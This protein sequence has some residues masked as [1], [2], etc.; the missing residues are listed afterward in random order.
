MAS[1]S[2]KILLQFCEWQ[3]THGTHIENAKAYL[4]GVI[5]FLN[6]H[7]FQI[8]RSNLASRLLHPQVGQTAY[9]WTTESTLP[10]TPAG[11]QVVE[12]SE[13]KFDAARVIEL[14]F[15]QGTINAAPIKNSPIHRVL[16]DDQSVYEKIEKNQ[17]TFHYPVLVD[18]HAMGAT[19]YIALP[20]RFSRE[21]RAFLSFASRK[22]GGL[23]RV[24][25]AALEKIAP[26]FAL[27]WEKFSKEILMESLLRLYLGEITGPQVLGGKI[28]RGEMDTIESVVWFSDIR[29]FTVMSTIMQPQELVDLLNTY[30]AVII[31]VIRSYGGEV[32]KF[33]GDGLLVVFPNQS[34]KSKQVKYKAL[35]AAKKAR[36][37][38]KK[39]N[40]SRVENGMMPIE[41]GIGLH[42]GQVQ[43]GNIGSNERLD[44]TVIGSAVN[45]ASRIAGH[46]G[47]LNQDI[48]MSKTLS[49]H[50]KTKLVSHGV[51]EMKGLPAP[52]EVL[53]LV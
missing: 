29:G 35:I 23:S 27:R 8:F 9:I 48:L 49:G 7:G 31:P 6:Q 33:L 51:R 24:Q 3:I 2:E 16:I 14:R 19:A 44:F 15:I 1:N 38:L 52:L 30:Y 4:H 39:L 53:S 13:V 45:A 34:G 11:L 50:L 40:A 26:L 20:L 36:E 12:R 42:Y 41:H 43:Y 18:L 22:K 5:Q 21:D 46:C 47:D 10:P 28:H 17:K 25:L 37:E 32:L